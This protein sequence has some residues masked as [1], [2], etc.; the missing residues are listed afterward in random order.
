MRFLCVCEGGTVR[1]G[2]AAHALK[3]YF[4]QEAIAASHAK[5][6]DDTMEMLFEWADR[7]ILMQP[8]FAD[9]VPEVYV[10]KVKVCDVGKDVWMNPLHPL[11]L[12][13]VLT[14]LQAWSSEGWKI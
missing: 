3:Y 13:K 14:F 6:S 8:H 4:G 2:S 1:S 5:L 12:T 11:L 7:I 10:P 9:R